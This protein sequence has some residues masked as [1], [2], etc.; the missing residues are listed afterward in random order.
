MAILISDWPIYKPTTVTKALIARMEHQLGLPPPNE[1]D[2]PI[3][4]KLIH[5]LVQINER[6]GGVKSWDEEPTWEEIDGTLKMW[7]HLSML[8]GHNN[9]GPRSKDWP[10]ELKMYKNG[11]DD[12]EN[13]DPKNE[14]QDILGAPDGRVHP[15]EYRP[16]YRPPVLGTSAR[17][18][19]PFLGML[20]KD[21]EGKLK[22][23]II[24][25]VEVYV[26]NPMKKHT[27]N[28]S[29]TMH[30]M[31]SCHLERR[32]GAV[33]TILDYR[34]TVEKEI[35]ITQFCELPVI[36]K[37]LKT[38]EGPGN[39]SQKFLWLIEM[40]N[41]RFSRTDNAYNWARI[42]GCIRRNEP[43]TE[44][45]LNS[46][47]AEVAYRKDYC[48]MAKFLSDMEEL[49]TSVA[50]IWN[51]EASIG[52]MVRGNDMFD[53]EL[54]AYMLQWTMNDWLNKPMPYAVR[55]E[56]EIQL[57]YFFSTPMIIYSPIIDQFANNDITSELWKGQVNYNRVTQ[58][59]IVKRNICPK[60]KHKHFVELITPSNRVMSVRLADRL[61]K[62][63]NPKIRLQGLN[64]K[65]DYDT[66]TDN[67]PWRVIP[68]EDDV[69][70]VIKNN[71]I[72]D[73]GECSLEYI[74]R[75][76]RAH[77]EINAETVEDE[78]V[79]EM[80][81]DSPITKIVSGKPETKIYRHVGR[82]IPKL[83]FDERQDGRSLIV[84]STEN[85]S[86]MTKEIYVTLHRTNKI[87]VT[88]LTVETIYGFPLNKE[89]QL[90]MN[91]EVK[92][93][94][95]PEIFTIIKTKKPYHTQYS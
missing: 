6:N 19:S 46:A 16:M 92:V 82:I 69:K 61:A 86:N 77:I 12:V 42:M 66:G 43:A 13:Y 10:P 49:H 70:E 90:D 9:Q 14:L 34:T 57:G 81:K 56:A 91:V 84:T 72:A 28:T 26:D 47:R 15:S 38:I 31:I 37:Y 89:L 76:N 11:W 35:G 53:F 23:N 74:E 8:Q 36:K 27:D 79:K 85:L 32:S 17:E 65:L 44:Q 78:N 45:E 68:L 1:T 95:R 60:G 39:T 18:P 21:T 54:P 67:I 41:T 63:G 48:L 64:W 30:D 2:R 75:M 83:Q 52:N 73:Y 94:T 22:F 51:G 58:L 40:M 59:T 71:I 62:L 93:S 7:D 24:I 5:I 20:E 87:E 29:L 33:V 50:W 80:W 3:Y 88:S 55:S 4:D 25:S